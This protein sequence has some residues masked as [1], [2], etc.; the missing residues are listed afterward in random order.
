MAL[1]FWD[2][3]TEMVPP[4]SAGA[5]VMVSGPAVPAAAVMAARSEPGPESFEFATTGVRS[6]NWRRLS[7]VP[8]APETP[9]MVMVCVAASAMKVPVTM[10]GPPLVVLVAVASPPFTV[11]TRPV[12]PRRVS[13]IQSC[14]W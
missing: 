13:V 1:T 3:C 9:A 4:L 7:C 8:Y 6:R 10:F 11:R 5:K 14:T 2:P 12:R